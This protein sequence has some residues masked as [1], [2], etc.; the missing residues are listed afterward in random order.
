VGARKRTQLNDALKAVEIHL[1]S[2]E[3]NAIGSVF[4]PEDVA[5][6]RYDKHSWAFLDSEK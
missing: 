4:A 6:E 3:L 5:G 1:S 2:E